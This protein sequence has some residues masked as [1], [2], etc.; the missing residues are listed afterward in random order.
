M[1]GFDVTFTATIEWHGIEIDADVEAECFREVPMAHHS[2]GWDPPEPAHAEIGAVWI[3][4]SDDADNPQDVLRDMSPSQL[5]D[6]QERALEAAADQEE[7]ARDTQ[8]EDRMDMD[9]GL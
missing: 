3:D 8:A 7:M 1:R 9:R 5:D 2:Y 6:L 4:I